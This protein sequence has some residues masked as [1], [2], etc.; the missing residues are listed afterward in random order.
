VSPRPECL[1][2]Q[3]VSARFHHDIGKLFSSV[4][5]FATYWSCFWPVAMLI[6]KLVLS[7]DWVILSA[8]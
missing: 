4:S 2:S 1:L 6:E 3:Q 8:D 7:F 5:M